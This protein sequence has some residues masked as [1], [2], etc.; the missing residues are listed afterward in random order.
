MSRMFSLSFALLLPLVMAGAAW[1]GCGSAC[2]P[3]PACE[4]TCAPA[5]E[6]TFVEKTICVP[7]WVTETRTVNVMECAI[8]ERQRTC[9][10]YK[11]VPETKTIETQCTVMVPEVRTKTCNYTVCTPVWKEVEQQYTVM[12][13]EKQVRQGTRKVCKM[14][15][16]AETRTV[17]KDQGCWEEQVVEVP[18]R[19]FKCR[20][21]H[22]RCCTPCCPPKVCTKKVWVPNI[23]QEEVEVTRCKPVIVEEPYEYCVT[24]CKPEVR[25]RTV[26]VCEYAKEQKTREVQYTVCV[27]QQKTVTR[28]VCTVKCVPEEKV[29]TYKVRVPHC[30]QKEVEVKV[31]K[32]VEKTV[33]VPCRPAHK[34]CFRRV[35]SCCAPAPKCGC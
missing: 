27:P 13:P 32:M 11:R 23:V 2:C 29:I 28:Q 30:V 15:K 35:R 25:T 26:K 33:Q 5:C 22:R 24:V 9:T 17:C 6:P 10:V 34:R 12:V 14:E 19:C 18:C 7:T 16:V 8:E 20:R 4:A 1:A 31:C 21:A 3:A